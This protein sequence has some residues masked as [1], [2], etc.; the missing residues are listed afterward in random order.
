MRAIVSDRG[1]DAILLDMAKAPAHRSMAGAGRSTSG[2]ART[3]S[4][5]NFAATLL[6]ARARNPFDCRVLYESLAGRVWGYL[7]LRGAEDPEDLTSEVFLRVFDHLN[8]FS[9]D[10]RGFTAWVFTIAHRALLDEHRRRMRRPSTVGF[11]EAKPEMITG[12]SLEAEALAAVTRDEV[13]ALLDCLTPDQRDV[14]ALR[15]V[16]DLPIRQVARVLNKSPGTVKA[17]QHRGV[18]AL[19][20]RLEGVRDE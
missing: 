5:D 20:R 14:L 9:G 11:S 16:A 2:G 6:G 4:E 12:N 8:D 18:A 13:L 19:R 17:L 15:I 7:R 10:S 1:G 3:A